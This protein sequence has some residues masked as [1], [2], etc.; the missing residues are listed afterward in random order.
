MIR[1]MIVDD[2]TL[3]RERLARFVSEDPDFKII[4]EASNG[5]EAMRKLKESPA[6]EVIFL[7][8]QMPEMNGLELASYLAEWKNPPL[9]VFATAYDEYAVKAFESHAIDY[10][11]KPYVRERL[12]KTFATVK[13]QV[14]LRRPTRPRLVSLEEELVKAGAVQRI[15]GRKRNS[16]DRIMIDPLEVFYFQARLA[17]MTAHLEGKEY[18]VNKT[19]EEL[20]K[21]LDPACFVQPHRAYIVNL[22]KV[23]KVAPF[24][25]N[26]F[27]LVLSNASRT[28]I[29]MSRYRSQE[30][31]QRL[32]SW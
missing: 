22:S 12:Q 15:V 17:E 25:K 7:D 31:K 19:L 9:I 16:K 6:A 29:P 2:E 26:H 4:A 8:I 14:R 24:S 21:V 32:A 20:M 27:E 10:V 3:A 28:K 23:E 1:V 30:I 5:I 13:E 11:L 18:V